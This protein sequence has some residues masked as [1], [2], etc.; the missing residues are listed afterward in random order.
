[1]TGVH[2]YGTEEWD[3]QGWGS[4]RAE[5]TVDA[6]APAVRVVIHWRRRD[7]EPE[8]KAIRVVQAATGALV[9]HVARLQLTAECGDLAFGPVPAAG[10]YFV[11]YLPFVQEGWQH[12]P[13][14]RYLPP[15]PEPD[16]GWHAA[17][18]AGPARASLPRAQVVELQ[19]NGD[20]HRLDPME[21]AAT[22][23]EL[24]D[25]LRHYP[26]Q[27][28]L[29]F[30]EDRR[31]PIRMRHHLPWRWAATGP[32]ALL[33]GA[34]CRGEF[35]ALQV[36]VWAA[37]QD[38]R[39]LRLTWTELRQDP[40]TAAVPAIPAAAW[41]CLNTGGNDWLGR[42]WQRRIDVPAATVQALWVGVEV[43]PAAAPGVYR[44]TLTVH[45]ANAPD[46]SVSVALEVVDSELP[47][48]GD[49]DAWR[50]ARLRWLDS[51]LGVDL[52]APPPYPPLRVEGRRVHLSGRSVEVGELGLPAQITTRFSA[53]VQDADSPDQELLAGPM[54][55]V[56]KTASGPCLLHPV[57]AAH[58]PTDAPAAGLLE[59]EA[60]AEGDGIDYVCRVQ[61][62]ADG[63][64]TC[65]VTLRA[66]RPLELTDARLEVPLR[67]EFARY[68]MGMGHRGG[69]RC[70]DW[71]WTWSED[72]ANHMVWLG[73]V[74]GGLQCKLMYTED[75]WELYNLQAHGLPPSWHNGGR[76]G[77]RVR[78][79]AGAVRLEAYGGPRPLAAGEEVVFRF[80]LLITPFHAVD[81]DHWGWRYF[82][83]GSG[84]AVSLADT[85]QAG[86]RVC[87]LHHGNP[88]NPHINYPF[89][90]AS[91]LRAYADEAHALHL[92]LIL[93]YTVRELSNFAAELWAFRSLGDEIYRHQEGFRLADHFLPDE[94][95]SAG[96][97][98][99]GGAWLWEHL[100]DQFVPAW[101]HPLD[102]RTQDAAIAT[103]GL[104]RLHNF[105]V[106][107]LDWLVR[108]A[109]IDG[110]YLD[111]IGYDRQIMK[112]VRKVL[113]RARPDTLIS[114]HSGNNFDPRYGLNS[115]AVQYLEHLPYCDNIWFGEGYDYDSLPDYW[116]VEI[117]GLPFGL[118]GEMLQDGGNP[119]RGMLYCG[120][121]SRLGWTPQ[122]RPESLWRFF[123]AWDLPH[124]RMVGYWD[125]ACPVQTGHGSVPATAYVGRRWTVVSLA[126]WAEAP[127]CCRLAVSWPDLG[128]AHPA[129][130]AIYAPAIEGFQ[131]EVHF[132]ID[133]PIPVAP[134]KGWLL[135]L[136]RSADL[137]SPPPG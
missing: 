66:T 19:A 29:V 80:G 14:T 88:L 6:A 12:M 75:V 17:H 65:C 83:D 127:V 92:R 49:G 95:R 10:T 105:Y 108:R 78:Q 63:Y 106:A 87:H 28:Y 20:F 44:G 110:L 9:P 32:G 122:S 31:F 39:D 68:M 38:L 16:P 27:A 64:L 123:D 59:W 1:M 97:T 135:V 117:S 94:D 62:E 7:P 26:H 11:Y 70:G 136:G 42:P 124:S 72:R 113:K 107:G 93:Y 133:Q 30:P 56:V 58:P 25:L 103:Q 33:T 129:E 118:T 46:T 41:R 104:S 131:P 109:G 2:A 82:G 96:L 40:V 85:A 47:D 102:A 116:L 69:A 21:V 34:A 125:P 90:T 4:H 50:Q 55:W 86:A 57:H 128:L 73:A 126:S 79:T 98:G 45:P 51:T 13:A 89:V 81:P 48:G 114:F 15:E 115:P 77:C 84:R 111:G 52:E 5:V 121:T 76:G 134:G 8:R 35:Y 119:W 3:V 18:I 24:D 60:Q 101:H 120:M 112:R 137:P 36:G 91:Q 37:R 71:D 54:R 61:L 22:G 43:P 53:S 23:A 132:A 130:A 67:P 74:H 99:G 100:V